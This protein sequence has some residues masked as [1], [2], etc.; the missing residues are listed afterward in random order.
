MNIVV[1]GHIDHGKST[2]MGH[3]LVLGGGVSEKEL[4]DMDKIASET[5]IFSYL[6]Y[7]LV[8]NFCVFPGIFSP[9]VQFL[10]VIESA[11]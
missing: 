9:D 2:T 8:C 10:Q 1:I 6:S 7:I 4:R 11:H 3:V 5:P